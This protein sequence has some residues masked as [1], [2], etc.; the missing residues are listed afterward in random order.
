MPKTKKQIEYAQKFKDP[1]WQKLRLKILKRD[2]FCC[3]SCGDPDSTLH[4]HHRYYLALKEPWDYPLEAFVT[5]CEDC[6]KYESANIKDAVN[7]LV[8]GAKS[9]FLSSDI[10]N[11]TL[12]LVH[13]QFCYPP[14]VASS[15]ILWALTG[16][17]TCKSLSDRY[18]Q[19]LKEKKESK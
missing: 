12:S 5:L 13:N 6:H 16:K 2:E 1:R 14:E 15:I 9:V 11:I 3:Q 18:F 7:G 17:E 4:V 10:N 19:H 8:M